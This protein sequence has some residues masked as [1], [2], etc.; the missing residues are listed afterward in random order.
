MRIING[1]T[2]NISEAVVGIITF[3]SKLMFR[4]RYILVDAESTSCH[5][6]YACTISAFYEVTELNPVMICEKV[7]IGLLKDGDIVMVSPDGCL[8]FLYEKASRH[9]ALFV[10]ERC[11]H[12]CIICPQ[13]PVNKEENKTPILKRLISLLPR[14]ID[15]I[16]I[17]GGEP[18]MLDD[19]LFIILRDVSNRLPMT[20]INILSNGTRFSDMGYA[21]KMLEFETDNL[22]YEIPLYSDL[23]MVHNEIV[24][25][26]AFY[27][28]IQGI[29]NLLD[30]GF[31]VGIRNVITAK[32][33]QRL[34]QYA[35]FIYRNFPDSSQVSFLQMETTGLARQNVTSLWIDPYDY[36]KGLEEAVL[37]LAE[38]KMIPIL[39][40]MQ[41]CI[42]PESLHPYYA[43]SISEWKNIYL[44]ECH[45][46]SLRNICGGLFESNEIYHSKH[47]HHF[48]KPVFCQRQIST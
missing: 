6:G 46:C 18:T 15:T 40:N 36:I 34:P 27:S 3:N 2:Y 16:G 12:R 43:R 28:T 7:E 22:H 38:R 32:N 1:R 45:Q 44:E 33:Y 10:T 9:N 42:V 5:K 4:S 25:T 26:S 13:P 21:K 31:S 11:N 17:T 30:L 47:I 23:Y 24:G 39:L 37:Y 48:Q 14:T 29:H 20:T 35:E 8:T 41:L 19:K